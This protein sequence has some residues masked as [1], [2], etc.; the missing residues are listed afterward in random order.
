[1]EYELLYQ[2]ALALDAQNTKDN[3]FAVNCRIIAFL[4]D[5]C[6]IIVPEASEFFIT[7]NVGRDG[8]RILRRLMIA[9][10]NAIR[11]KEGFITDTHR[12]GV[13]NYAFFAS[14]DFG[15]TAPVWPQIMQLGIG[16]LKQ[17]ILDRTGA[18][19]NPDFVEG[20]IL[21]FDA[22]QRFLHRAA[23]AAEAAGK[24]A[25]AQGIRHLV[26]APP[27]TLFQCYQMT[28][29]FYCLQQFF[30][31]TDIRTMGRLDQLTLPFYEKETDLAAVKEITYRYMVELDALQASA[32]MP[33]ALAGT[34]D[35]GRSQV[36]PMSYILLE[37][38]AATKLP[39]TK[40]H[41]LCTTDMPR[42]FL[43][44]AMQ[45]IKDGGN[46]LV[47]INNRLV[48]DGLIKLGQT[49][50]DAAGYSIVGCYEASGLEEVPCSCS[51]RF[52]LPKALEA[53]LHGGRDGLT[54]KVISVERAV[55]FATYDQLFKAF[56][57][58][59]DSFITNSIDLTVQYEKR[60]PKMQASPFFSAC[61]T[62]CVEQG[63]D[64]Y[65]D[66]AARYNNS[67]INVIGIGTVSDSLYA[68]R[69]LVYEEKRLTLQELVAILDSNWETAPI[70]R[71]TVRN[72]FPKYGNGIAEVDAIAGAIADHLSAKINN[73]PNGRNGV[74][75]MGILSIDWRKTWGVHTAA[76]ADGR[77]H[78]ET[79][80]QNASA[81]FGMDKE[82]PTGQILSAAT[83]DGTN[84]VNGSVLDLDLHETMV[85]G[86]SGTDV[87]VATLEAFLKAGGHTVHYNVLNSDTLRD[88]QRHPEE[89]P[90][91][92]VRVCGWNALFIHLSK[93]S[94]DE[95]IWRSQLNA[96]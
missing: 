83:L 27:Q 70:L 95:F 62:S 16:G 31:A 59:C 55:D 90:N 49:P 22:A 34:D 51:T 21:V 84:A 24:N 82:G 32:N 64:A 26:T 19:V 89:Y 58:N 42:D 37:A 45:C 4:L 17:R 8:Q 6:E 68:I 13:F 96:V 3:V 65:C 12:A 77:L 66:N 74:F 72:K 78:G 38:Y 2:K 69:R 86:S 15:H 9:R 54:G 60:Y 33:F 48:V 94:Q 40:L 11:E 76:S 5:N 67:S 30:D 44:T 73:V 53:T 46:S 92:Q 75:R 41:I 43:H 87:L 52:S 80:S 10:R 29:L 23:D 47:F 20:E 39:N 36:N 18:A 57:D 61:L 71:H 50:A 93:E 63:G 35:Q 91:L 81:A 28:F 85:R 1:M 25:M 56:L 79:L 7:T 88:A 14:E